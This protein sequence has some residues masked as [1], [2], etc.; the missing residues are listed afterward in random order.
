M[1]LNMVRPNSSIKLKLSTDG[2]TSMSFIVEIPSCPDIHAVLPS[3]AAFVY[4]LALYNSKCCSVW[5]QQ[6]AM[7]IIETM[8]L[9]E[10]WLIFHLPLTIVWILNPQHACA[11]RVAVLGL[12]VCP[13]LFSPH[14]QATRRP[15][16][17]NNCYANQKNKM[18]IFLERVF[19]RYAVKTS[20]KANMHNFTGLPLLFLTC[21][22]CVPW[23]H[24]K[25]QR[26]VCIGL[27]HALYQ[28]SQ[29]LSDSLRAT[30]GRSRVYVY[31]QPSPSISCA[32][33]ALCAEDLHHCFS[34]PPSSHKPNFRLF[35]LP[36]Y[37]HIWMCM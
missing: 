7:C 11:A 14:I 10:I 27:P 20:E 8:Y 28:C 12:C 22:L 36:I 1:R 17:D 26:R 13:A 37:G 23:R 35:T 6:T 32:T 16:S 24:K 18:V 34:L 30:S 9:I 5:S 15:K 2:Q 21:L 25:S 4:H 29:P 33:H 3:G 19:K 31:S